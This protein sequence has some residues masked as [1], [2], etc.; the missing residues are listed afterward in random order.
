MKACV[1]DYL[2]ENPEVNYANIK[3]R[4]GDPQRIAEA[5][6]LELEAGEVLKALHVK[7]RIFNMAVIAAT[8]MV[9]AWLGLIVAAYND[10]AKNMGGYAVVEVIEIENIIYDEGDNK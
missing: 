10:H 4:F 9:A 8:I 2:S 3:A 5:Y 6:V 1:Q 7:R